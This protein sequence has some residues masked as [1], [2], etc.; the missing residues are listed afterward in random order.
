MDIRDVF[1]PDSGVT[2][3]WLLVLISELDT[4][5]RYVAELNGGQQFR[6]WD[7]DRWANV[8][9]LETLRAI[10]WIYTAAH[11]DKKPALPKPFPVPRDERPQDK[12]PDKPGSFAFIAKSHLASVKKRKAEQWQD[13]S[14]SSTGAIDQD[15]M[16]PRF[17]AEPTTA[18]KCGGSH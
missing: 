5:S 11:V 14:V 18:R 17:C 12:T 16:E 15:G 8:F 6:G 4:K 3:R 2:P 9:S 10:Q 7:I 13:R 1:V